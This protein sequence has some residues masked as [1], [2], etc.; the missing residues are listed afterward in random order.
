MARLLDKIKS[1]DDL[2]KLEVGQ[3]SQ[4]ARELREEILEHVGKTGGHLGASLGA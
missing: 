3:L 4:V 1:P 2:K